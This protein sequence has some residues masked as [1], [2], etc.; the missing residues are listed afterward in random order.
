MLG[1][2]NLPFTHDSRF[3][4][5]K[6]KKKTIITIKYNN[7]NNRKFSLFLAFRPT[8]PNFSLI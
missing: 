4:T 3:F 7:S 8:N 5:T 1:L 2:S 6:K